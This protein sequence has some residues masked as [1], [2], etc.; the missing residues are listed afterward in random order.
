MAKKKEEERYVYLQLKDTS[1]QYFGPDGHLKR[2]QIVKL[3]EKDPF[4]EAHLQNMCR[5]VSED[6]YQEWLEKKEKSDQVFKDNS[7]TKF[8]KSFDKIQDF[9]KLGS[10]EQAKTELEEMKKVCKSKT[11]LYTVESLAREINHLK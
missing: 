10:K 9:I 4:V 3:P 5:L 2:D 8:E 11:D 1:G 7:K 6:D